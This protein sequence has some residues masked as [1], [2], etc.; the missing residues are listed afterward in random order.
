MWLELV[1]VDGSPEMWGGGVALVRAALRVG[2][3]GAE[4][5]GEMSYVAGERARLKDAID[6]GE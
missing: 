2:E 3:G 4:E 5:E 1:A 6:V